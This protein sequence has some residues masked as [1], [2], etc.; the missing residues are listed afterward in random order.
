MN[1]IAEANKAKYAKDGYP[2]LEE[3]YEK[4]R[5]RIV[6]DVLKR[7]FPS[8]EER[9]SLKLLDIGCGDG[10]ITQEFKKL[11]F[12]TFGFDTAP[13]PLASAREKGIEVAEGNWESGLPYENESF[14]VIF[15]GEAIEHVFD[16]TKFLSEISR[17]LK[18]NGILVVT[19]PNLASLEDR[20]KFLFGKNPT[21]ATPIHEYLQY[22][23]RPFTKDSLKK[24]MQRCGFRVQSVTSN[25]VNLN[26]FGEPHIFSKT[27]AK[28][29]PGIGWNL[30]VTAQKEST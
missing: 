16:V 15:A 14:D 17:V 7:A 9:S 28:M 10:T 19:T 11:G 3:S 30:I 6:L 12:Q 23:I 24:S 22:H 1:D 13:D 29:F 5:V 26:I 25:V 18:S 2:Y 20:F 27:L 8:Q 21:H 4:I